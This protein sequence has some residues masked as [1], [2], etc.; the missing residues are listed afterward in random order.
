[1]GQSPQHGRGSLEWVNSDKLSAITVSDFTSRGLER[2]SAEKSKHLRGIGKKT[3]HLEFSGKY[4][5]MDDNEMECIAF[6][7][8]ELRHDSPPK[9]V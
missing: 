3:G 4:I 5:L 1:M 9:I 7:G 8:E 2:K 6:A